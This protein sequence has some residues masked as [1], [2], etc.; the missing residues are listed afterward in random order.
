MQCAEIGHLVTAALLARGYPHSVA[1]AAGHL[2]AVATAFNWM[3][4]P[5]IARLMQRSLRTFQRARALLEKDGWIRTYLLDTGDQLEGQR[6]PVWHP[7]FVRDVTRLQ[8]LAQRRRMWLERKT[9]PARPPPRRKR[10][11]AESSHTVETASVSAAE[12]IAFTAALSQSNGGRPPASQ[13][14]PGREPKPDAA[15]FSPGGPPAHEPPPGCPPMIDPLEIDQIDRELARPPP[16][17]APP[18]S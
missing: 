16:S 18:R 13:P 11:A 2:A 15:P 3:G 6:A 17:R 10:S 8:Q 9:S 7:S 1:I 4:S 12:I 14:G 5:R